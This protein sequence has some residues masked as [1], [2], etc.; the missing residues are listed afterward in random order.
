MLSSQLILMK[1]LKTDTI[2][3]SFVQARGNMRMCESGK[4]SRIISTHFPNFSR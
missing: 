3:P 1:D 2:M 4:I